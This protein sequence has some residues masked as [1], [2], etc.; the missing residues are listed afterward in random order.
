ME[1]AGDC[2]VAVVVWETIKWQE[3]GRAG[4]L[5]LASSM[6]DCRKLSSGKSVLDLSVGD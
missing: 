1:T 5:S 6:G 4:R 2:Q 3:G